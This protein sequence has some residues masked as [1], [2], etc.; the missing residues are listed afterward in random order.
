MGHRVACGSRG[1]TNGA[2]GQAKVLELGVIICT[3]R[4]GMR[5]VHGFGWEPGMLGQ[6][7]QVQVKEC[8]TAHWEQGPEYWARGQL[9]QDNA[10]AEVAST[11]ASPGSW[12]T[13]RRGWGLVDA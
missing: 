6:E 7:E 1:V 5:Y 12:E 8:G 3:I 2:H 13:G 10:W 4:Q 11:G 9:V